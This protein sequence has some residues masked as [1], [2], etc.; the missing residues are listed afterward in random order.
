MDKEK[1]PDIKDKKNI[2]QDREQVWKETWQEKKILLQEILKDQ[3]WKWMNI[4]DRNQYNKIANK[5]KEADIIDITQTKLEDDFFPIALKKEN[6]Q[7]NSITVFS[8]SNHSYFFTD[9]YYKDWPFHVYWTIDDQ[10][11]YTWNADRSKDYYASKWQE[12]ENFLDN[13]DSRYI[14]NTQS[15]KDFI[16]SEIEKYEI[17]KWDNLWKIVRKKYWLEK[18]TQENYR[19]IANIINIIIN[20]PQNK[21]LKNKKKINIKQEIFLPKNIQFK[22]KND[23]KLSIV[24]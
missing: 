7:D 24:L 13:L 22:Y 23:K 1:V 5:L 17:K 8:L 15:A 11:V 21:D 2:S 3:L 20:I 18:N 4:R 12:V 6:N 14:D 16:V 10:W 9:W 19:D